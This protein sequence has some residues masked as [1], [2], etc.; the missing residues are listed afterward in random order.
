MENNQLPP[1]TGNS[2]IFEEYKKQQAKYI[3]L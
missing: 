3:A 2:R 1:V